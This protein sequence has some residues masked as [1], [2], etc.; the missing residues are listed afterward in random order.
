MNFLSFISKIPW[1]FLIS[2]T[3]DIA[4]AVKRFTTRKELK[5]PQPDPNFTVLEKLVVEQAK[6]IASL[7]D[8]VN[9]LKVRTDMMKKEIVF[10]SRISLFM[11]ILSLISLITIAAIYV[12]MN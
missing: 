9:S 2:K 3:P 5:I 11:I 8:E 1:F 12:K 10:L 6:L 7:S 4:E